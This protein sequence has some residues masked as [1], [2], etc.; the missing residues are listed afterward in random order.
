MNSFE[1][2]QQ[3][4][5]ILETTLA[6]LDNLELVESESKGNVEV[7]PLL[8]IA[9]KNEIEASQLAALWIITTP[10][11]DVKLGYARQAGDEAKHYRLIEK[12]LA[13]MGVDL[14][15]FDPLQTGL[16]PMYNALAEIPD[17]V[18]RLAAGQFTREKIALKRN[19]QFIKFCESRGDFETAKLYSETIQPDENYHHLLGKTML[20]K[21]AV[22]E[23]DQ[24]R[25]RQAVKK[26]LEIAEELRGIAANKLGVCQIPGC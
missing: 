20:E 22:T 11:I 15:G 9:L 6:G 16:S 21:Y 18:S 26:T 5:Q 4:E 13:E 25:A 7:I 2:V 8:K 14:A 17:T 3:M 12:R 1:F 23:E 10:E 24:T 19:I